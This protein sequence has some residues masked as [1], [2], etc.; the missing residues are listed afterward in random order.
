MML[1]QGI[2]LNYAASLR[3]LHASIITE[4]WGYLKE[5]APISLNKTIIEVTSVKCAHFSLYLFGSSFT[6]LWHTDKGLKL[7]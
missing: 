3:L 6:L 4:N 2:Y 7:R 5:A 1:L